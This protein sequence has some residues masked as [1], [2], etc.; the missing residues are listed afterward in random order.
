LH[1]KFTLGKPGW[2]SIASDL[3]DN[4]CNTVAKADL[5]AIVMQEGL[6]YLCLI[7]PSMTVSLPLH[8]GSFSE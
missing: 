6:A 7:T 4:A 1:R 8:F 3:V 5:A 2:D